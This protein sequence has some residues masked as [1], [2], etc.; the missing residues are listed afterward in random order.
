M[1]TAIH[2]GIKGNG[3]V[4][5]GARIAADTQ[6]FDPEIPTSLTDQLCFLSNCIQNIWQTFWDLC[7]SY[8]NQFK[9]AVQK[10]DM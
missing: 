8:L 4:D 10:S 9:N 7:D 5:V 3:E 1:W 2:V 6:P